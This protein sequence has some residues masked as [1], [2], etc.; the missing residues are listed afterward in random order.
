MSNATADRLYDLAKQIWIIA[1]SIVN[2][3]GSDTSFLLTKALGYSLPPPPAN[4]QGTWRAPN[5]DEYTWINHITSSILGGPAT[6]YWAR[7]A[8]P[9]EG[10]G[11]AVYPA[12]GGNE[13]PET[14]L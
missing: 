7:V 5:G 8:K 9:G 10:P 14:P 4:D 2:A 11:A 12:T 1:D 3:G 6:G 13:P